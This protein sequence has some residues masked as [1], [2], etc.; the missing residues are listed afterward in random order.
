ML[1]ASFLSLCMFFFA[2]T[3]SMGLKSPAPDF[4]AKKMNIILRA[5]E[6]SVNHHS[7]YCLI[8]FMALNFHAVLSRSMR[9]IENKFVYDHHYYNQQGSLLDNVEFQARVLRREML[10]QDFE[11]LQD[12][13]D[14][15][16]YVPAEERTHYTRHSPRKGPETVQHALALHDWRLHE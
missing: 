11:A 14:D 6:N 5:I 1:K 9:R 16:R 12:L 15:T 13:V 3:I 10:Q 7:D 8:G 4:E 2:N